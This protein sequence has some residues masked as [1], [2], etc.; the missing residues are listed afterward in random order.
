MNGAD[1][2]DLFELSL[3]DFH[4]PETDDPLEPSPAFGAWRRASQEFQDLYERQLTTRVGPH[5]TLVGPQGPVEVI[6]MASL[7]YLGLCGDARIVESQRAALERWG[8]GAGG[9]PLLSGTTRLHKR[10][11]ERVAAHVSKSAALSFTSGFAAAIGLAV[12]VLRRGDVAIC[13][14]RAHVS[15]MDAV[16]LSGAR[17]A[18][19]AHDDPADL[20]RVLEQHVGKRR[21]VIVDG[22]YSMDGDIA[23]LPALLDVTDEHGVGMVVDEAHSMFAAGSHGAGV[24]EHHRVTD[25]VRVVMGTYSKALGLVGGFLA[26]DTGLIDYIRYYAHPY[27]FSSALPPSVV[28]GALT[29][30]ELC[31]EAFERREQLWRN[32]SHFRAGLRTMGLD[33]G[34]SSSWVVPVIVGRD[35][36]LLYEA[37]G[38]L[39]R[40]GVYVAPVDF[41]A[42]PENALRMRV[43][44]SAGH[45]RKDLDRALDAFEHCV[46]R[47]LRS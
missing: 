21:L 23:D 46:A 31:A 10:L 32:A 33:T 25:R 26:G 20:R 43:A 16:R 45:T 37:T 1:S 13:D 6:N 12:G 34:A 3:G 44:I 29:G 5:G 41:P 40:C 35:R 19:F 8:N 2:P 11:E 38:E 24:V 15:W 4:F 27:V 22:L 9:V 18:T 14:E 7:D 17:L 39:M 30:I 36:R 42:V 47:R 28:A